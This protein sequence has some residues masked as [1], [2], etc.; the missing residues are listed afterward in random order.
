MQPITYHS[1]LHNYQLAKFQVRLD[2]DYHHHYT[3]T[4]KDYGIKKSDKEFHTMASL[5]AITMHY[6]NILIEVIFMVIMSTIITA[7]H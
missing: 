6:D 5:E 4:P 1:N 7:M 3:T 2:I